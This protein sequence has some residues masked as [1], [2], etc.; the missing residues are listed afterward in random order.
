MRLFAADPPAPYANATAIVGIIGT[1]VSALAVVIAAIWAYFKFVKG[2]TLRPRLAIEAESQWLQRG[3]DW[4]IHA[5]VSLTNI[6]TSKI[7][8]VQSTSGV[9]IATLGSVASGQ[10]FPDWN[11]VAIADIFQKHSWIEPAEKISHDVL[12]AVAGTGSAMITQLETRIVCQ[13]TLEN[14]EVTQVAVCPADAKFG[15]PSNS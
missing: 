15:Q 9:R 11:E 14:I 8:F 12:V 4:F 10:V 5:R 3:A 13:R 6:G 2:R 7:T 1:S